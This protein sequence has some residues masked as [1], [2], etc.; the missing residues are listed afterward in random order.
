MRIGITGGIGSGKSTVGQVLIRMGY[1]LY[2][3][4]SRAKWLIEHDVQLAASIAQLMGPQTYNDGH[5][6]RAYVAQRVFGQPSLL[7]Q[8]N[9]LVHPAVAAD[10]EH[11]ASTQPGMVFLEAAILFESQ[12]D[13]L[14]HRTI[15]VSA[16]EHVR[17]ERVMLRDG[18]VRQDVEARMQAQMPP[19][20][21]VC[22]ANFCVN[23]DGQSLIVP[24]IISILQ[25]LSE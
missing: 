9:A 23:N 16:P 25:Q 15:A 1:P 6:N 3:A 24:Q 13:R 14:V 20:E 22:R 10:F 21:L 17:I 8:L 18:A 2:E 12:F 5:Y 19:K 7:Q 11:W 4:D